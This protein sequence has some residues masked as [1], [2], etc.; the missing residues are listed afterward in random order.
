MGGPPKSLRG[1]GQGCHWSWGTFFFP[2]S[3]RTTV[4][5]FACGLNS[6]ASRRP[7]ERCLGHR[8]LKAAY[9][10]TRCLDP[11]LIRYPREDRRLRAYNRR[12]ARKAIKKG[13]KGQEHHN[14]ERLS[15]HG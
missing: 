12:R 1:L 5:A 2:R 15:S 9:F 13:V 4:V 8:P 11:E 10:V 3:F 14:E 7:R 6:K